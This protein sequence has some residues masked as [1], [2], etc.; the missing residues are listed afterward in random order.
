MAV[1]EWLPRWTFWVQG[2]M[3]STPFVFPTP[4]SFYDPRHRS[5]PTTET[6]WPVLWKGKEE[7]F[8]EANLST[9]RPDLGLTQYVR[10]CQE[11]Q[12]QVLYSK[13]GLSRI[14]RVATPQLNKNCKAQQSVS[15]RQKGRKRAKIIPG[16][17]L[18]C[19]EYYKEASESDIRKIGRREPKCLWAI[20]KGLLERW[21]R[22]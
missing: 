7:T 9:L 18:G 1:S 2:I 8:S 13:Q 19:V 10:T 3:Y 16:L 20:G 15:Y 17:W 22:G 21:R 12:T 11:H 14:S 4:T 5:V 6:H